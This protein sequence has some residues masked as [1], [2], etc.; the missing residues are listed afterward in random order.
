MCDD[1]KSRIFYAF[2]TALDPFLDFLSCQNLDE[3]SK[4]HRRELKL[5][6]TWRQRKKTRKHN[7]NHMY[8]QHPSMCDPPWI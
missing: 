5:S 3:K 8:Q 6:H 2:N 7:K 1:Q 4:Q